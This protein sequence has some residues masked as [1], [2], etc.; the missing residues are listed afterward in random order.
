MRWHR[1]NAERELDEE[2]QAHL[3][4]S[5]ADR[6]ARGQAPV[7]AMYAA[8]R[9]FGNVTHVKEVT[10][11]FWGWGWLERLVQDV[12]YA[13][14]SLRRSPAFTITAATTLALGI[15][16]NTTMFTIVHS[17]LLRP[18]PF[19]NADE[20]FVVS[21]LPERMAGLFGLAMADRDYYPYA[22]AQRTFSSTAS[23]RAFP[24]TLLDAGDPARIPIAVVT[25]SFFGTLG[26]TPRFGQGFQHDADAAGAPSV[27]VISA[28]LW[29]ERFGADSSILGK[30][31][32]VDDARRTIVGIMPDGFDFPRHSQ[33]W[34]PMSR[35]LEP[36]N[37][38]LQV[39]IGRLRPG[40]TSQPAL[41]ELERLASNQPRERAQDADDLREHAQVV[42]LRDAVV[43][44]ARTALLIFSGAVGLVLLIACLNVS[45]L[46]LMRAA[47]RR[48]ELG[49]RAA[50]GAGR[51]RLVRALLTE[52]VLIALAGGGAGFLLAVVCLRIAL[53]V[54]PAGLLPRASEVHADP[55]IAAV[56]FLACVACGLGAGLLPALAASRRDAR[57][58]IADGGRATERSLARGA[59]V[60]LETAL[61]LVLLVGAGLTVRSF[62]RLSS[63]DLG[64]VPEHL[65][66]ATV[67]LPDSRY[68]T[69]ELINAFVAA[70]DSRLRSLPHVRNTT[71]INWLPFD[72]TYITGTFTP[73][74][75]SAQ[76]AH[77]SVLK[78]FV[79]PNYFQTMGIRIVDG[80]AFA[81]SDRAGAEAV[82]IVSQGTA[83]RLWPNGAVGHR[84]SY[85]DTP[86]PGD[87]ITVVGVAADVV[88][89]GPAEPPPPAIYRPIAQSKQI[90]FINHLTFVAQVDDDPSSMV[91]L[92]RAAIHGVD[93]EQPIRSVATMDS[94][95]RDAVAEPR[96]RS[97]A[98]AVFSAL[99]LLLAAVGIYGVLAYSVSERARELGIR[100]ALGASPGVIRRTVFTA[101][102]SLVVPG[103]ILGLLAAL[104]G[105][106]V[107]SRFL[108][109]VH[110]NDPPTY[111]LASVVV[112]V[113]AVLAGLGPASR[114]A[115]ID[116]V[117][118]MKA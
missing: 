31:V 81:P 76:T 43:G 37:S 103:V 34:L 73:S 29:R 68:P 71:A 41:A 20:L 96:V 56:V 83:K 39:V 118:T 88:H 60:T 85:S 110:P 97:I 61:S 50:L 90:F 25:P 53:N 91:G 102:A 57:E 70:I 52:S 95:V 104:A 7:D 79:S 111:L 105:T 107:L 51:A 63:V 23:Y 92:I 109:G 1:R 112:L 44:D 40:S 30:S 15:A 22:G 94:H 77:F 49:I 48:R 114:A 27:A 16:A 100:L 67:D 86:G 35:E 3:A 28:S 5:A 59:L 115:R 116:P 108:F 9:E 58:I 106:R 2:I 80:R 36:G 19:A 101:V 12:R 17:V 93:P 82:A 72:S 117:T 46:L 42:P 18:L 54:L 14:R 10:R 84:I 75:E 21:R 6:I 11:Q 87:W 65:V 113:A 64:F 66:T 24:A 99:A 13:G 38:R 62:A 69:P 55:F 26:V 33:V 8:R 4:L 47:A 74:E 89:S 98:S 32:R 78:P 45:N